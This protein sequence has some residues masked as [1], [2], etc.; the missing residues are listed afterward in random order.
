LQGEVGFDQLLKY[1]KQSSEFF[2]E[3]INILAE[4]SF[5]FSPHPAISAAFSPS[6]SS[7]SYSSA[8]SNRSELESSYAKHLH[9]LSTKLAKACKAS[10]G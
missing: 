1:V 7:A 2:K 8:S 5:L 3:V 9:K 10:V 6:A 4:R